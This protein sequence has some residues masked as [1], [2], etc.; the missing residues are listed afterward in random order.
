MLA[1][2]AA[3]NAAFSVI[4]SA[5]QNA[6]DIAKAGKAIGDFVNAKEELR[7]RG[8]KK[9]QSVFGG[10]DIEEFF[11]LEQ[12]R[13][14]EEDLK[15]L[16]IYAGRPGLWN[17]WQKFQAEARKARQEAIQEAQRKRQQMLEI[18]V[19]AGALIL[20]AGVLI[21]LAYFFVWSARS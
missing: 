8:E 18:M 13:Q 21:L 14:Q 2:L 15:Q 4:K 5:V 20:G 10:N 12:I 11:A 3:A 19:I 17:D 1:E 7:V 6:G 16:M 9:R